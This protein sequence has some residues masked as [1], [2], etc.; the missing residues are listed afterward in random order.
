MFPRP[1]PVLF[2]FPHPHGAVASKGTPISSSPDVTAV[3]SAVPFSFRVSHHCRPSM[4]LMPGLPTLCRPCLLSH[5]SHG[6]PHSWRA[7]RRPRRTQALAVS[8]LPQGAVAHQDWRHHPSAANEEGSCDAAAP[9]QSR[10]R[11]RHNSQPGAGISA[12]VQPAPLRPRCQSSPSLMDGKARRDS[13]EP[14]S[15][16]MSAGGEDKPISRRG[17]RSSA[18]GFR[19][20]SKQQRLGGW[21]GT[22][23]EVGRNF[24]VFEK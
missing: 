24:M 13:S 5:M 21:G 22:R 17:K 10:F 19:A 7:A 4:S 8:R 1:S 14:L 3:F 18:A 2:P 16:R 23:G 12:P 20:C 9:P 6:S 15:S 11:R